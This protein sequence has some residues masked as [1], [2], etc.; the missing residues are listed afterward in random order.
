M[1]LFYIL[2]S[3]GSNKPCSLSMTGMEHGIRD[4][5]K[6]EMTILIH[7]QEK[8]GLEIFIEWLGKGNF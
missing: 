6:E 8:L 4:P 7:A 3:Q 5:A 1:G 2:S